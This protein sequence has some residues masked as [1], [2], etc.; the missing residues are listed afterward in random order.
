[1]AYQPV[2]HYGIIGNM[3][4]AALVGMNGSIDWL[5]L[6]HFD[7][8]SVFAAMLDDRQG[9]RFRIAPAGD[10][11]RGSRSRR[12]A[13]RRSPSARRS[14]ASSR[15]PRRR[16]SPP[17]VSSGVRPRRSA[18]TTAIACCAW[19]SVITGSRS[20]TCPPDPGYC[21][22]T[23]KTRRSCFPTSLA[24]SRSASPISTSMPSGRAR[25]LSTASVW[26]WQS[27]SAKNTVASLSATR[28][29]IQERG[30]RDLHTT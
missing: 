27:R 17:G 3:R 30:V 28:L 2:E 20:R 14:A 13:G 26:G 21:N 5:C 6:P 22:S 1:M 7:S 18:A 24:S 15:R 19:A 16:P 10:H 11:F 12:R 8:P 9:G 23:P 4:T 25:V 29:A